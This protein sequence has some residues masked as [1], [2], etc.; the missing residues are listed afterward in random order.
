MSGRD[1]DQRERV[2]PQPYCPRKGYSKHKENNMN[3]RSNFARAIHTAK[4]VPV[5]FKC[6]KGKAN[7][8]GFAIC[9]RG[10]YVSSGMAFTAAR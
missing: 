9:D 2:P 7:R 6:R 8:H 4:Q 1:I 5:L 3:H 10:L